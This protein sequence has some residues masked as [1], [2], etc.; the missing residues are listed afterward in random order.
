MY[1]LDMDASA[2]RT[3]SN[4]VNTF[5]SHRYAD[6]NSAS[7]IFQVPLL[8]NLILSCPSHHR[9][10]D[11]VMR[12][13]LRCL[14]L[15]ECK[16]ASQESSE[17]ELRQSWVD[18]SRLQAK[19]KKYGF[20]AE[21][22][23]EWVRNFDESFWFVCFDVNQE[24]WTQKFLDLSE[25]VLSKDNWVVWLRSGARE[26][27]KAFRV[28]QHE[29]SISKRAAEQIRTLLRQVAS[30]AE[31]LHRHYARLCQL[32]KSLIFFSYRTFSTFLTQRRWF[33]THGAHPPRLSYTTQVS[34]GVPWV[35]SQ[36]FA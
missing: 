27:S 8:D 15:A 34:A 28:A 20:M 30:I 18:I 23:R 29:Q 19:R 16:S 10:A 6:V 9:N 4:N 25:D 31:K 7:S 26:I 5:M 21:C 24:K 35:L 17:A 13:S 3:F 11:F 22:M 33:V 32:A 36:T 1:D 2:N 12:D 14:F